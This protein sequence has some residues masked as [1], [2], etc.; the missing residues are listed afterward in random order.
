MLG[1]RLL[2]NLDIEYTLKVKPDIFAMTIGKVKYTKEG[3]Q[4]SRGFKMEC[5]AKIVNG[6]QLLTILA[7]RSI[8]NVWQGAE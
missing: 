1:K 2:K 8:F 4:P 3:L 6:F 5:F 7:K